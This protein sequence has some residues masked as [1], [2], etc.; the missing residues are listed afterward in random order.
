MKKNKM[1]RV[2]SALVVAV[3][4]SCCVIS[5]TFAKYVTTASD[6][7]TARVAKWGVDIA[8]TVDGA[9][10]KEYDADATVNDASGTAI[11]KTVVSSTEDKLLAPGT[12]GDLLESATIEGTPEVAVNVKT[13]AT[14]TLSDNWLDA[15]GNFYCPIV[16]TVSS[17]TVGANAATV[18]TV[19]GTAYDSKEDFIAAVEALLDSD[20][21]YAP[22]TDLATE[23][24]VTWAWAFAGTD[25]GAAA[26][27]NDVDDTYLGDVAAESGADITIAFDLVIT[28]TQIN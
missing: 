7:D 3:L 13:E 1:M 17:K 16:I 5:G 23:L 4:L 28:V 25:N 9:F 2:A 19:D 10:A 26:G 15:D 11:A 8:V 20:I 22:N 12:N 24:S 21:N 27:Q 6:S 14:L 18:T